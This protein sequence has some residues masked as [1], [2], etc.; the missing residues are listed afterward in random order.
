MAGRAPGVVMLVLVLDDAGYG[1]QL[2]GREP[3]A[4]EESDHIR[5]CQHSSV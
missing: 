1:K 4:A 3:V 2:A 5:A